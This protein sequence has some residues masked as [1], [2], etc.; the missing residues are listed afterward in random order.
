VEKLN[1]LLRNW[2]NDGIGIPQGHDPSSFLGNVYLN[3]VDQAMIA[4]GFNYYRFA[5]DIKVF[6]IEEKRLRQA[7]SRLTELLRPLNLH[8][9]GGKTKIIQKEEYYSEKLQF[10]EEMDAVGYGLSRGE[11][12]AVIEEKLKYLWSTSLRSKKFD[13]T[14]INFCLNRFRKIESKY[15]LKAVLSRNFFDPSIAP[16]VMSYLELFINTKGVQNALI[17]AFKNSSYDYERIFI[18]KTLLKSDKS[19]FD[20][21]EINRDE[22]YRSGNF[23]LVG[24]YLIL[25][26]KFGNDGLRSIVK[27]K[28]NNTYKGDPKVSR[29]FLIALSSNSISKNEMRAFAKTQPFLKYTLQYLS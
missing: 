4:E 18:L 29:Y 2:A 14:I 7:I 26:Y 17:A 9:S 3:E 21:N 5:D 19:L 15:A 20:F 13:K 28:F 6:E 22:I 27:T 12:V 10:V 11:E 16:S 24:Y 23:M 8:L 25:A 1:S